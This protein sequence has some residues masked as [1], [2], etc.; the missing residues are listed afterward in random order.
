MRGFPFLLAHIKMV[1]PRGPP[2]IDSGG[3]LAG[4]KATVLPE[5]LTRSGAPPPMQTVDHCRRHAPRF[6]NKSRHA[7]SERAAFAGRSTYRHSVL[8]RALAHARL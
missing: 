2:P 5:I 1:I 6:E 7:G 8:I 4:N 3:G